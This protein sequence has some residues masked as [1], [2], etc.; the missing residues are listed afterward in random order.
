MLYELRSYINVIFV[1]YE[2]NLTKKVSSI[3][4][5]IAITNLQYYYDINH[6]ET[7]YH[8]FWVPGG[9]YPTD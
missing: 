5:L 2:K 7:Q 8:L 6:N 3:T 9:L 4:V 1:L